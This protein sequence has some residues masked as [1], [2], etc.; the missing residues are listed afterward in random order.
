MKTALILKII[1]MLQYLVGILLFAL[2]LMQ[3]HI[4]AYIFIIPS[5]EIMR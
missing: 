2:I 4:A 3:N 5:N 1:G